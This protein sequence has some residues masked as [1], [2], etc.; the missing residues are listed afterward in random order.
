M[1]APYAGVFHIRGLP[2]LLGGNV[3]LDGGAA[4]QA[5]IS[6]LFLTRGYLPAGAV[7]HRGFML[8]RTADI[9]QPREAG[10]VADLVGIGSVMDLY[11]EG[12]TS[13][14]P[15][16][17]VVCQTLSMIVAVAIPWPMHIV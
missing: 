15:A 13:S 16:C 4:V 9:R 3:C 1:R 11:A 7:R 5:H 10:V 17:D 12:M 14:T 6:P 8:L 2:S